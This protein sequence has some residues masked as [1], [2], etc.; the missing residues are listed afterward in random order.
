MEEAPGYGC[1]IEQIA[2]VPARHVDES[3]AGGGTN[4]VDGRSVSDQR[5]SA[6]SVRDQVA[7]S[8]AIIDDAVGL[9]GD[10]D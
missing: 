5:I 2:N 7:C 4:V 10:R 6:V 9:T 1:S 3:A 8:V